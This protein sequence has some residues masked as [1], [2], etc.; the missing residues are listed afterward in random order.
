MVSVVGVTVYEALKD[1]A[2][3]VGPQNAEPVRV[4]LNAIVTVN[5]VVASL[6]V[7]LLP[8]IWGPSM[9]MLHAPNTAI[10]HVKPVS[11]LSVAD[12]AAPLAISAKVPE[13]VNIPARI[14]P[15]HVPLRV[16]VSE[17]AAEAGFLEV[18]AIVLEGQLSGEPA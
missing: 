16:S 2:P 11:K 14:P 9:S 15:P 6:S 1:P 18:P 4:A 13:H 3:L 17:I 8:V 12:V 10:V 5:V 7:M